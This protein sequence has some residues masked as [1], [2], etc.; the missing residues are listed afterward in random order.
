M[1]ERDDVNRQAAVWHCG[2]YRV[3][4]DT[5]VI[6]AIINVT[7]D[8]FSGD[9]VVG[10]VD[11]ALCQAERALIDGASILDIGGESSRPGALPV[12]EDEELSRVVPV[13]EALVRLGVPVS[14]DTVKPGVMREAIAAGAAIINDINA[15]RMD[16]AIEVVAQSDAGVCLM[17]MQGEP[18]NMQQAPDYADI[19]GDV[20]S[21]LVERVSAL[22]AAGVDRSRITLDPGFGFGKTLEH[23][24]QL[25]RGMSLL[26]V[27]AYPLLVGVSRKSMLGAVTGRA[28][29]ERMPASI[30]TAVLAAQRGAA[31]L[32]VHDVAATRDALAMWAAI[33][34]NSPGIY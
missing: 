19:V 1:R 29:G 14:V 10:S 21:F 30:V 9:G 4:L 16:G 13:V 7:P 5:P 20:E 11:A 2:D 8:S 31:I 26:S 3:V 32:R 18:R 23:N 15:L 24:L 12:S 6:M 27:H 25:F 17:H 28:V 22:E 33:D 34:L